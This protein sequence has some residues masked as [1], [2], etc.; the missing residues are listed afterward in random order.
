M[1]KVGCAVGW[2]KGQ[3]SS[4]AFPPSGVGLPT[5]EVLPPFSRF[6]TWCPWRNPAPGRNYMGTT[7]DV[8]GHY[9]VEVIKTTLASKVVSR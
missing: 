8:L 9:K 6:S 1:D 4:T 2:R 3:A 5:L 7:R